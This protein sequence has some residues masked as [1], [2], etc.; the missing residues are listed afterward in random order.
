MLP[1][2]LFVLYLLNDPTKTLLAFGVVL[3][4]MAVLLASIHSIL[5]LFAL[6]S[7]GLVGMAMART[8]QKN[9]SVEIIMI[10]PALILLGAIAFYV[11]YSASQLSMSP[12][13]LIEKYFTQAVELN[14]KLYSQLP[15]TPEEL[16]AIK[17]S[18]PTVIKL[19]TGIFPAL[20]I[21]T[22]LFTVWM[23]T[24]MGNRILFKTGMILPQLSALCEWRAPGWLVWFF[25]AGGALSLLAQTNIRLWGLNVFLVVSAIYL[26]QGLAIVSFFFQHKN[27]PFF[28]RWLGYFLIAIQQIL[29]IA[30]AAIG[31]FDIWV[32]FRKYFRKDQ[33]TT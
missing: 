10:L 33:S 12:W 6:T 20:C 15:L 1:T 25:I 26:L 14:I 32:D 31:L 4:G 13:Q 18:K 17:D 2:V 21:I 28:F 5:P 19:F 16:K 30:I 7:M 8:A 22:V 24:L 23:N 9:Y 3:C 29:M 27:I 11:F